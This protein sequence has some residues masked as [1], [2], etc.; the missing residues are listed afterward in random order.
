MKRFN[1]RGSDELGTLIPGS[2]GK[3][4]VERR[5]INTVPFLSKLDL[6]IVRE[7][8]LTSCNFLNYPWLG[9]FDSDLMQT[10]GRYPFS[11]VV[12]LTNNLFFVKN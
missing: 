2:M 11:A 5:P 6:S 9:S 8:K 12:R 10:M 3:E 7:L 1:L 4:T